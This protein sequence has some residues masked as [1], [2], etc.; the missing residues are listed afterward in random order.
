MKFFDVHCLDFKLWNMNRT[1]VWLENDL[2][3]YLRIAGSDETLRLRKIP[4]KLNSHVVTMS[5]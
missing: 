4:D 3:I 5:L 1:T 2:L